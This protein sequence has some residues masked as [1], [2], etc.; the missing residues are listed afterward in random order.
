MAFSARPRLAAL[1]YLDGSAKIRVRHLIDRVEGSVPGHL[2][3]QLW[4]LDAADWVLR[5]AGY[6][7]RALNVVNLDC[8]FEGRCSAHPDG[9]VLS[10]LLAATWHVL[11]NDRDGRGRPQIAPPEEYEAELNKILAEERIPF[12]LQ[13]GSWL[14]ASA[15]DSEVLRRTLLENGDEAVSCKQ[16]DVQVEMVVST[17]QAKLDAPGAILVDYGAGVGRILAGLATASNFKKARYVAVDEPM[18][19]DVRKL[20]GKTGATAEFV[21]NRDTFLASST[22]A[23]VIMVVNTLHHVPFADISR[24]LGTL[25][26]KLRQGGILLVHEMGILRQPEQKNVA[27]RIEDLIV[28]FQ[29]E[30]FRVNP[31]STTSKSGVP[32]AHVLVNL[33]GKG[34]VQDALKRNV[35]SVWH[36]MKD[37][38][39]QEIEALYTSKDPARHSDLQHALITNANLDLNRP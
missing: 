23:D 4:L 16:G 35:S 20:A 3:G 7:L 31:R 27:W 14:P 37:R 29:G 38:V 13:G 34:L 33:T 22:T 2:Q 24:Q 30:E 6:D 10:L 15:S 11:N 17:V 32:L 36:Q 39:L 8:I 9:S 25:A 21:D 5:Q 26:G 18:P 1:L 28:L 12:R 19:S